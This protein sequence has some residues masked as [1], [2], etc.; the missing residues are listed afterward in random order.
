M[1]HDARQDEGNKQL[2]LQCLCTKKTKTFFGWG[3]GG[4]QSVICGFSACCR[5]SR[6]LNLAKR[7]GWVYCVLTSN[8]AWLLRRIELC[9]FV[10]IM[11]IVRDTGFWS[12]RNTCLDVGPRN[13]CWQL[14]LIT[15]T[16]A[17]QQSQHVITFLGCYKPCGVKSTGLNG[18]KVF[19]EIDGQMWPHHLATLFAWL[20]TS[21]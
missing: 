19:M 2:P 12:A 7:E 1:T 15:E 16:Y 10:I 13:L 4:G 5:G 9:Y 3:E 17:C 20:Y 21:W 14:F 18:L 6:N 8:T 11:Q